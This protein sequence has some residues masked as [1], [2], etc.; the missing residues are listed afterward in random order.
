MNSILQLIIR[1]NSLKTK[2]VVE[3]GSV[4]TRTRRHTRNRR[5][6]TI[7]FSL[8]NLYLVIGYLARNKNI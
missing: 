7:R 1:S 6:K 4:I 3:A 5:I 2:F 8:M